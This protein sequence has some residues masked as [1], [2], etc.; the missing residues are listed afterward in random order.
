[1]NLE[2]AAGHLDLILETGES[3]MKLETNF[4]YLIKILQ[5]HD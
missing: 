1:M 3:P 5:N 4:V 2:T